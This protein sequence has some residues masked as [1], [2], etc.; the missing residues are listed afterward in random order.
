MWK[1]RVRG[2]GRAFRFAVQAMPEDADGI[3]YF[4]VNGAFIEQFAPVVE[5]LADR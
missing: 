1:V 3:S 2:C 4:S 5:L